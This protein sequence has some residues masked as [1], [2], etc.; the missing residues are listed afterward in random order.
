MATV[1][2]EVFSQVPVPAQQVHRAV[3]RCGDFLDENPKLVLR[4]ARRPGWSVLHYGRHMREDTRAGCGRCQGIRIFLSSVRLATSAN[5]ARH[6]ESPGSPVLR[7]TDSNTLW[8]PFG[9]QMRF[10]LVT[11]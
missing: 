7:E 4:A 8:W 11:P 3:Q 2:S 1:T 6:V 10:P 5:H 9:A